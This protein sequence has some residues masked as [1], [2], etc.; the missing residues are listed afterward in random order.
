MTEICNGSCK[1]KEI[2]NGSNMW[3]EIC[4]GL[5]STVNEI[6]AWKT[7]GIS[8]NVICGGKVENLENEACKW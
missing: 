2:S 5:V 1:W 3:D 6:N 7:A 8:W 4:N